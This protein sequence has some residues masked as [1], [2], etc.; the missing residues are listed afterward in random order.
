[1]KWK[2]HMYRHMNIY[3]CSLHDFAVGMSTQKEPLLNPMQSHAKNVHPEKRKHCHFSKGEY[4]F[5]DFEIKKTQT[6]NKITHSVIN[7]KL[8]N[9]RSGTNSEEG[10]NNNNYYNS[11]N[12][13]GD[14]GENNNNNRKKRKRIIPLSNNN[15]PLNQESFVQENEHK[16]FENFEKGLWEIWYPKWVK[17]E[18]NQVENPV[19]A[20][21][22][23][24]EEYVFT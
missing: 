19:K 18:T 14:T 8:E 22:F 20:T 4:E 7:K 24:N 13:G 10:I 9:K 23:N 2:K 11:R 1:M 16:Q 17:E 21:Y 15:I 3:E 5:S 12:G 6:T